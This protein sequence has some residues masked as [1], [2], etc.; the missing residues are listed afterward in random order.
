LKNKLTNTLTQDFLF[1]II[2][3]TCPVQANEETQVNEPKLAVW[4]S[5]EL[6]IQ[7]L[8]ALSDIESKS[9]SPTIYVTQSMD[10]LLE[11]LGLDGGAALVHIPTQPSP[12]TIIRGRAGTQAHS[13]L[14]SLPGFGN[15]RERDPVQVIHQETE[16]HT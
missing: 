11:M 4:S 10:S 12:S 9:A 5:A 14:A 8:D 16:P 3:V 2:N 7:A 1:G 15:D 6:H 13:L